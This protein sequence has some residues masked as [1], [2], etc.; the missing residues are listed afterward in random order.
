VLPAFKD[1]GGNDWTPGL[2]SPWTAG[3]LSVNGT[4]FTVNYP[5]AQAF[6]LTVGGLLKDSTNNTS[7]QVQADIAF[8]SEGSGTT[9]A[10]P[11]TGSQTGYQVDPSGRG[12][13]HGFRLLHGQQLHPPLK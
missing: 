6:S 12:P 13:R 11:D 3:Q 1:T 2:P 10:L 8:L 7:L 9:Y 5:N 4:A